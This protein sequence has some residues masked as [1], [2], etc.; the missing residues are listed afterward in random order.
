MAQDEW[1]IPTIERLSAFM[2]YPDLGNEYLC[3]KVT[4]AAAAT[5]LRLLSAHMPPD[6]RAPRLVPSPEGGVY[7]DWLDYW[8]DCT[9]RVSANGTP[10]IRVEFKLTL[11]PIESGNDDREEVVGVILKVGLGALAAL[12][13]GSWDPRD[14]ASQHPAAIP[15]KP[16]AP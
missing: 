6:L 13:S 7:M 10:H 2:K 11:P 14:P 1:R 5:A 16:M 15:G 8:V 3:L 4:P 9:L 12:Q